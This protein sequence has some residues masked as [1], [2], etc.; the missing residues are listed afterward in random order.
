MAVY[1]LLGRG[2]G[3][4]SLLTHPLPPPKE[5]ISS[6]NHTLVLSNNSFSSKKV[7]Y[8]SLLNRHS[9]SRT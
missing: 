7:Y 6:F 4:F 5:G 8:I 2:R 9:L 3:G 1:P